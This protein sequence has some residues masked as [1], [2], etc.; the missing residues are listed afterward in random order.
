[1]RRGTTPTI[2]LNIP[3]AAADV[4]VVWITFVSDGEELFTKTLSDTGVTLEDNKITIALT[5]QETLGFTTGARVSMQI[6]I[7]TADGNAVASD[8]STFTAEKILKDG[9]IE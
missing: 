9:V 5:Q 1:M 4:S 6:R 3:F 2:T 8:I 7:L